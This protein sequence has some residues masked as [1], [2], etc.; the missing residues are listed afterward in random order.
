MLYMVTFTIHIPQ[1]DPMGIISWL[2]VSN[3]FYFPFQDVILPD[4]AHHFSS[5]PMNLSLW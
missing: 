4:E 2:V 3:E 5:R 1:V